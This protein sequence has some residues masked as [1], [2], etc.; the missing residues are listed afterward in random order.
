MW[1]ATEIVVKQEG[2]SRILIRAPIAEFHRIDEYEQV[3]KEVGEENV[4]M[5]APA[6]IYFRVD[7]WRTVIF[8]LSGNDRAKVEWG[9]NWV[10][11][12]KRFKLRGF[13]FAPSVDFHD[14]TLRLTESGDLEYTYKHDE[15]LAKS[16]ITCT[17]KRADEAADGKS[18]TK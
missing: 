4:S 9:E 15:K 10:H 13:K 17:L 16:I 11:Y 2:C 7:Q 14:V 3:V 12:R 6:S 18:G 1:A 8:D 5:E